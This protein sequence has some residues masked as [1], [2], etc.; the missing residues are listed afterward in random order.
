M[1]ALNSAPQVSSQPYRSLASSEAGKRVSE[2]V[3]WKNYY[4]HPDFNYEWN[5]GVL[6][7]VPMADYLSFQLYRWFFRLLE[8]YLTEFPQSQLIGLEIG[9]ALKMGTRKSVRKPDLALIAPGNARH[10]D[11]EERSF[12]GTFDL[13]I[14]FLSDST[15]QEI[16]RD[17]IVKKAEYELVGVKE[18]FILDRLGQH[19]AFYRLNEQGD[20]QA[21]TPKRGVIQ[22]QVLD[23]FAFRLQDLE[24]MPPFK[25]LMPLPVY[26]PF[27]RK[28][29]QQERTEKEQERTE[30]E[31]ALE[32]AEQERTEK[33]RLRALLQKAGIDPDTG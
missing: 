11:N 24:T 21:I 26:Q 3:Y 30:K 14:E 25:T 6:E 32:R 1:P 28:D 23:G 31:K 33:E 20:Y 29:L 2:E 13:C 15:R 27:L 19:T 12:K 17:T 9:F 16:E 18:Y 10:M 4:E 7:E 8:E 22:S 5:N